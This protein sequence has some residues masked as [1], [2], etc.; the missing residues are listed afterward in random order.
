RATGEVFGRKRRKA[1]RRRGR[2]NSTCGPAFTLCVAFPLLLLGD[3][4]A[5]GTDAEGPSALNQTLAAVRDCMVRSPAPWPQAWQ[6]EYIETI[7]QAAIHDPNAFQYDRRLHILK[8][9][10]A[11]YWPDMRNTPDRSHFDVRR[12]EIRWYVEN[13][14][15]AELPGG[16]DTALLRHQYEDLA[17][18]AA[19]GLLAQF[20]F[21]DPNEVRN[22]KAAHLADCYRKIDAPLLP[23]FLISLSETQGEQIK[24]RWRDSRYA[25]VDL[26]RSLGGRG[27]AQTQ[28]PASWRMQAKPPNEHSDYLLTRRCLD[29]LAGQ[30]WSLAPAPPDYYRDA[31]ANAAA[32]GKRR[33]RATLAA[34]DREQRLGVAVWQTEYLGFLLAALLETS[35]ENVS[36]SAKDPGLA[37]PGR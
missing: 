27:V 35:Q 8:E 9:G 36:K 10:F 21:L 31:A 12:A 19:E 30:L 34:R 26:W 25:R 15:A 14:M 24:Q 1:M 3:A 17:N 37:E 7:R 22:A 11:L 29:Q 20:S 28:D 5:M 32:A 33:V 18:H 16:E 6:Q 13:L 2:R 23:I 4:A